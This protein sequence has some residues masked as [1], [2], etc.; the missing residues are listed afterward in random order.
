[1]IQDVLMMLE[2]FLSMVNILKKVPKKQLKEVNQKLQ[3]DYQKD[4]QRMFLRLIQEIYQRKENLK[5]QKLKNQNQKRNDID[6]KYF[7]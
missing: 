3:R 4:Y 7:I 2:I 6:L 1:M 5:L